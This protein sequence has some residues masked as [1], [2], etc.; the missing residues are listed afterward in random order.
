MDLAKK[1]IIQSGLSLRNQKN[2]DGDIEIKIIGL[3]PGEK[4]YEELLISGEPEKTKFSKIYRSQEPFKKWSILI[5][6]ILEFS[7]DL[8]KNINHND[9]LKNKIEQIIK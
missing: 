7:E 6:E 3:R 1:I 2:T 9:I 4:I 5:N 8:E